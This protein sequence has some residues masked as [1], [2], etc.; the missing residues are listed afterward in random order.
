M[1]KSSNILLGLFV[2]VGL[3]GSAFAGWKNNSAQVSVSTSSA[4]GSIGAARNSADNNQQLGC[5]SYNAGANNVYGYCF[6]INS[7]GTYKQCYWQGTAW[8][9]TINGINDNSYLWFN[10][11]ASGNCTFIYTN[12]DSANPPPA[13]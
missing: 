6:A 11:D 7:T 12:T 8:L 2:L 4:S 13:P 1:R 9:N 10:W 3:C 5:S